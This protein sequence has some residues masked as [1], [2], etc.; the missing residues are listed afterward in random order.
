MNL[1]LVIRSYDNGVHRRIIGLENNRRAL[2][3]AGL[4]AGLHR[5]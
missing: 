1:Q 5:R 4:A 2:L 3:L